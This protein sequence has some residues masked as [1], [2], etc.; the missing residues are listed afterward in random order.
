MLFRY[1]R[2]EVALALGDAAAALA[3][4]EPMPSELETT[5]NNLW[6]ELPKVKQALCDASFRAGTREQTQQH[7][8][9]AAEDG[10]LD[11]AARERALTRLAL[12]ELGR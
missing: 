10:A 11:D 3:D 9:A 6:V 2:A 7:C 1:A 12:R 8:T 4:L 5:K